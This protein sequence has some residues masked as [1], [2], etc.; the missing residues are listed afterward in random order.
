MLLNKLRAYLIVQCCL[1]LAGGVLK[2]QQGNNWYFGNFAGVTFNVNPPVALTNGSLNTMEGTSVMS[3]ENGNLLFYTDGR[4]VF[5]RDHDLMLNG[6][7]LK[8]HPSSYQSCII[9]PRPGHPNIYYIFTSD[10]WEND[11]DDGYCYSE[12]DMTLDGGRGAV[13]GVKNVALISPSS[14][15]IT[16]IKAD[17]NNSY[18]VVTNV[19]GSNNFYSYKVDCNGVSTTP[20]HSSIGRPMTEDTYC[21]IGTLRISPDGKLLIQT[22]VKGR[23]QATPANEY[24]QLFDFNN[25]TGQ[26]TNVREITLT[27]NGY[28]FGAEFS[29]DSRLLYIVNPFTSTIH[30]F[31]V[32]SGNIAAI[33]ASKTVINAATGA[34]ALS[35]ISLGPDQKIYLTTGAPYLH[36]INKPNVPGTGC[37]LVFEQLKLNRSAVLAL[38]NIVSSLYA[39]RPLD[40]TFQLV[41]NCT[42]SVQFNALSQLPGTSLQWDFGDGNTGS[43]VNPLHTYANPNQEYIVKVTAIDNANCVFQAASKRVRPS[44]EQVTADFGYTALCDQLRVQFSD[45]SDSGNQPSYLWDFGD[46]NTSVLPSPAH[47]YATRGVYIA[48]LTVSTAGGCVTDT[49]SVTLDFSRPSINAGPD[50]EVATVQPIQLNATGGIAYEWKPSLYLDNPKI[51]NP[52]MRARDEVTYVVTGYNAGGCSNTDTLRVTIKPF[53]IIEVPSAFRPGGTANTVLRPVLKLVKGLNYFQ[54]YNRWGQLVFSTNVIGK[55]WDGTVQGIQQPTGAYVWVLEVVEMD[56]T[57]VRRRG[58]SVLVR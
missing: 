38:P 44:G 54:V 22:N 32:S 30:Q 6:D 14:E 5:N 20:V 16:A 50:I 53:K 7:N 8:G 2:A 49:K 10:A 41:G 24:A 12:V 11:G 46:G 15:R 17:D 26:L 51:G 29:P 27:N 36:V 23:A 55:G 52:L 45:S 4:T 25:A 18:W 58:S 40:L 19:W 31:D 1:L 47:Q 57:L 3:D 48:T 34:A 13:T 37:D 28:Y 35:G 43:G 33:M 56:G 39:N 21:N 42:G 9:V